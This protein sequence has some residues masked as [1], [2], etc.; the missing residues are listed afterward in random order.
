VQG[1]KI[2]SPEIKLKIQSDVKCR[3]AKLKYAHSLIKNASSYL[4]KKDIKYLQL[5]VFN[6]P[7]KEKPMLPGNWEPLHAYLSSLLIKHI[8]E[9]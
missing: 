2:R 7:Q 8:K 9:K 5:L 1:N 4:T 6:D 3:K